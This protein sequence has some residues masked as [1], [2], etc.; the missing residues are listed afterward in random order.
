MIIYNVTVKLMH[1]IETDWVRWMQTEHIPELMNTGL[2]ERYQLCRLLEQ[3]EADGVTYVAQYFC[4]DLDAY[5]TY[6]ST[7]APAMR[8]QGFSRFGNKFIAFRTVME[9]L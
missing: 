2:F 8:E 5:N 3:D 6:I 7:F 1:D 4:R 9:I